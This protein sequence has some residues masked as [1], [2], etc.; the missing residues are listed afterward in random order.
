MTF[1][2]KPRKLVVGID[3]TNL[4][5]GCKQY[6]LSL[7]KHFQQSE[8]EIHKL[9]I[10]APIKT[11]NSLPDDECLE[12]CH[13]PTF[14]RNFILRAFWQWNSLAIEA[15]A[16]GCDLLFI[17][18][19]AY[20]GKFAPTVT[21]YQNLLPF[22]KKELLR[23][24]NSPASLFK[25]LLLRIIYFFSIRRAI[26]S[27]FLAD[28]AKS[29]ISDSISSA[30]KLSVVIPHGVED[31][32]RQTKHK[33]L[34]SFFFASRTSMRI[35]YASAIDLYKHP[36]HVVAAVSML[37]DATGWP[38]QLILAGPAAGRALPRLQASMKQFDPDGLFV[39]YLGEVPHV[40]MPALYA[41]ADL[42]VFAST[43]ENLPMIILEQM[44]MGLPIA[45]ADHPAMRELLEDDAEWFVAT[46]P[47]SIAAALRRMIENPRLCAERVARNIERA[48][49]YRWPDVARRTFAFLS[50]MAVKP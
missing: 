4:Q 18:G 38:L 27:I 12:K 23:F 44:A 1:P 45:S 36:W 50:D 48:D 14:E 26:A 30:N 15:K 28:H 2:V 16:K 43:C 40:D 6:I 46:Q 24:I 5:G 7:I 33:D 3:A 21:M 9:I 10:W 32:F 42:A 39:E 31:V 19:G 25:F 35:L 37:R 17:P 8:N 34:P 29:L 20:C 41:S 11:L 47:S 22:D 13:R 49:R